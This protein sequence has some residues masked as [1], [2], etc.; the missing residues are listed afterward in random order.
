MKAKSYFGNFEGLFINILVINIIEE[1]NIST[2]D[3]KKKS[4]R[5]L[6]K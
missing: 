1:T 4:S 2:N 3:I 5:F 6:I